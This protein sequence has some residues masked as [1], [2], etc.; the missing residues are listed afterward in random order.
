MKNIKEI[1]F[2][3]V[4]LFASITSTAFADTTII[5][6]IETDT[7]SI[8]NQSID[9]APCDSDND[10]ITPDTT[11]AYCTLVQSGIASDWS[12]LWINSINNVLNNDGGNGIYWMWLANLNID[13][14]Y[15]DFTC[16][17]DAPS[18]CSAKEYILNSNDKILFYYN[19]NPLNILIDNLN[20]TVGDT[21]TISI[22]ELGLDGWTSVWN[23]AVGGKVIINSNTYDLDS[24][25]A[26]SFLISDTTPLEIKGRKD[27][28][29]DTSLI[30]IT[31]SPKPEP[32]PEPE[33]HSSSGSYISPTIVNIPI[34][35]TFDIKK[36]FDFIIS[37]QNENGSFGEDIY[38][39]WTALAL[40]TD[41]LHQ[42][43]KNKIIKYLSE[44]KLNGENLTD[45]ERHSMALMA[46]GLN[47]YSLN[48]ENYIEK[49]IKNFD[50]IQFGDLNQDNDDIFALIVLQNAGY[51][52]DEKIITDTINFI[53]SKQKENGSWDESI[54]MTGAGI[55]AL[56]NFKENEQV[57]NALTKAKEYL[58]Q[59]QKE[60]GGW[61]NVSSTAWAIQGI[62]A[63]S[64]KIEDKTL[65]YLALNQDIDGGIKNE[66]MQNKIWQTSYALTSLSG[67][68][69]NQIMQK[70]DKLEIEA[71]KI[72]PERNLA[73]NINSS[74]KTEFIKKI[75]KFQKQKISEKN[76]EETVKIDENQTKEIAPEIPKKDN[77][78]KR[79]IKKIFSIF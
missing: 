57:K 68:T 40:A 75:S 36:A 38:T 56:A 22:K 67:K 39:D 15:S 17:Q 1:L 25:G 28:F 6:D 53:I 70:F 54:D 35:P 60:N 64:E 23:P 69:W 48:G 55:E 33:H 2:I 61:T 5:L 8:Y 79:L 42:D 24:N 43:Q 76:I 44:N 72:I 16:H 78:F 7:G 21:I 52:R 27:G 50:G 26:Y 11:S 74:H 3:T 73:S 30:N 51:T 58:K 77:W 62:L 18:G 9:V 32:P 14:P 37:Q 31:P 10:S 12:G 63:L 66:N 59:N 34:K 13:N 4:L 29:I 65:E 49:I 45:Y 20:P 71:P 19:T 47:P 41:T 46:L